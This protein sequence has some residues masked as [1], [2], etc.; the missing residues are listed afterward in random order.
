VRRSAQ[1]LDGDLEG[2]VNFEVAFI[3]FLVAVVASRIISRQALKALNSDQKASLMDAFSGIQAHG[4]IPLIALLA[5]Y[6]GLIQFTSMPA[7]TITVSYFL[8]LFVYIIW[9]YWFTRKRLVSLAL[10]Q[11]YMAKFGIARAIQYVGLG[12]FFAV[13]ISTGY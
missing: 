1:T 3:L 11:E 7:T 5:L 4:L 13:A 12:I 10:P 6:F 9:G 8:L 2:T